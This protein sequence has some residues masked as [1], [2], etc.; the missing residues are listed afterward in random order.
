MM[1]RKLVVLVLALPC[2]PFMV[3]GQQAAQ[4]VNDEQTAH[5]RAVAAIK[6]RDGR[7]TEELRM[8]KP[9]VMV[10][11]QGTELTDNDLPF[12]LNGLVGVQILDLRGT[13]VTGASFVHVKAH[14]DLERLYLHD[15]EVD[16]NALGHL[17]EL[18]A[19][20][21]L[22]LGGCGVTDA[23]LAHLAG[24]KSLTKLSLGS[25]KIGDKGLEHLK[26]LTALEWLHLS[27]TEVG[28]AGLSNLLGL[29][30]LEYLDLYC[31]NV[32]DI[33]LNHLKGLTGLRELYLTN[34]RV[35]Q[36]G[37]DALQKSL[38]KA[39]IVFKPKANN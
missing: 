33:G 1:V 24:I 32:S 37:V 3:G 23:G 15:R 11:L 36:T 5:E 20:Q 39:K 18:H 25:N 26:A 19:L 2:L 17:K 28:D 10:E 29:K 35:T 9:F 7:V 4:M 12:V 22:F 16:D 34:S 6:K 8:G 27:S 31:T 14:N 21:E 13:H 38:P 30:N